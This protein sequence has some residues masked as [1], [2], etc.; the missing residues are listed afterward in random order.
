MGTWEEPGPEYWPLMCTVC[1]QLGGPVTRDPGSPAVGA[2]SCPGAPGVHLGLEAGEAGSGAKGCQGG[3]G[4]ECEAASG[5]GGALP[6]P[7]PLPA[8][9]RG[10]WTSRHRAGC[11]EWG[12]SKGFEVNQTW[13]TSCMIL[14]MWSHLSVP[15]FL[16]LYNRHMVHLIG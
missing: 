16:H 11:L 15:R 9:K 4:A 5:M 14:S 8:G 12:Q 6:D 10:L 1:P 3:G 2:R 7:R 13:G